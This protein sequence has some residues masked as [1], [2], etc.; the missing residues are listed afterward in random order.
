M[1][2]LPRKKMGLWKTMKFEN[3]QDEIIFS[4]DIFKKRKIGIKVSGGADSAIVLYMLAKYIMEEHGQENAEIHVIT[5]NSVEKMFQVHHA[6]KV[7]DKVAELTG[8]TYAGHHTA[9]VSAESDETYI[10]GQ[11]EFLDKLYADGIIECNLNGITA[12]PSPEDC[13]EMNEGLVG[14]IIDERVRS[15]EKKPHIS[16]KSFRPVINLDKRG[17]AELYRNLG[18]EKE[19]YPITRSCEGNRDTTRIEHQCGKCWTC[20]ERIWAFGYLE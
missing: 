12:I 10:G 15:G 17:I 7:M 3:S 9:I 4:K 13:P 6:K 20:R 18:V 2:V 8:I 5:C 11:K 14:Q 19:L 1:L 16:G